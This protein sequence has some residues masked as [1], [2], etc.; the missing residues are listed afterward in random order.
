MTQPPPPNPYAVQPTMSPA[1]EKMWATL[2]HVGG[3]FLN[4]VA[5]LIGYL[6]FKD[7]GPFV[8]AHTAAAL[9]FQITLAIAYAIGI[10]LTFAFVGVFVLLAVYVLNMVFSILAALAANRGQYYTYPL[11]ITFV[12]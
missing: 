8:R 10:V 3:I 1:D 2:V 6:V 11:T 4:W 12:S 5:P 7:R 9:N